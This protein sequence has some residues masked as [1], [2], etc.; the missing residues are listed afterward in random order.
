MENID[1][2]FSLIGLYLFFWIFFI[3]IFF[4]YN[5]FLAQK[6]FNKIFPKIS[7]EKEL[8]WKFF[9]KYIFL[10]LS[11]FV[12]L[13]WLFEFKFWEI[14]SKSSL[15]WIDVIFTL[16]VSKSMNSID[17]S[18]S[19]YSYT[20]LDSAKKTI[21]DF[22]LKNWENRYWLVIFSWD[23]TWVLPLTSDQN[24][25]LTFLENVD[26][27]NL[28]VQWTDIE[29]ALKLSVWRFKDLERSKVVILV[30]DWWDLDY[31]P[32]LPKIKKIKDKNSDWDDKIHFFIAWIWTKSWWKILLWKDVF[33]RLDYQTYKWK[34]VETSLNEKSLKNVSI[35]LW[36]EYKKISSM[37]DILKFNEFLEKLEK[38]VLEIDWNW[39]RSDWWRILAFISFLFF[40]LFL[41]LLFFEDR[42]F[43]LIFFIKKITKFKN[44]YF[45]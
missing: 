13:F 24:V 12:L 34:Y 20:R 17:I 5:F 28:I 14:E 10:F 39:E 30:S 27:K 29:K 18:D 16:D 41:I 36:W 21:S 35:A 1:F 40:I 22:V 9:L 8:G 26:Y 38:R 3:S 43:R 32:D 45:K 19:K 7:T 11:L 15:K 42:I 23:A 31:E 37:L 2:T 25:F 6:K 44:I 33:W 4:L